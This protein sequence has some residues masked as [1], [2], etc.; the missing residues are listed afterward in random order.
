[1]GSEGR[2][3]CIT[4]GGGRDGAGGPRRGGRE[5]GRRHNYARAW[6]SP[7][8]LSLAPPLVL[9]WNKNNIGFDSDSD[10]ST[11]RSGRPSWLFRDGEREGLAHDGRKV[12][13]R[14][15]SRSLG[16][17][18]PVAPLMTGSGDEEGAAG[19]SHAARDR[20]ASGRGCPPARLPCHCREDGKTPVSVGSVVPRDGTK[21]R[22]YSTTAATR[23]PGNEGPSVPSSRVVRP[24]RHLRSQT[25]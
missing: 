3:N 13:W 11:R 6:A 7:F 19:G 15:K 23:A 16:R 12:K 9:T 14:V 18:A 10:P 4:S 1:M 24:R 17:V 2:S 20:P 21:L 8:K 25:H 22:P 5:G